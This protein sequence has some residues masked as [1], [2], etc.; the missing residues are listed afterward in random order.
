[1]EVIHKYFEGGGLNFVREKSY[2]YIYEG[3]FKDGYRH[4]EGRYIQEVGT[5]IQKGEWKMGQ[6][7]GEIR[8]K[9]AV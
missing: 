5:K 7:V 2:A 3:Q 6:F 1:M 8:T 9:P 4:G